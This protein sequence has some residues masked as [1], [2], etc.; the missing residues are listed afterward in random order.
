MLRRIVLIP[1]MLLIL[2]VTAT[3]MENKGAEKITLDGGT[4]G[5]VSLPHHHHQRVLGD[6]KIC[7]TLFPQESGSIARLKKEGLLLKKQVMKKLC[8]WCHR[9]QKKMGNPSGPITCAKCHMKK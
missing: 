8:I 4:R 6:C 3:A 1:V 5:M 9:D 7:H 2:V